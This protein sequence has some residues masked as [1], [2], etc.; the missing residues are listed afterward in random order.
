MLGLTQKE[1]G[2][3]LGGGPSAFVKYEAGSLK[4]ATAL[5]TLLNLL[6]ENPSLI[7]SI[8]DLPVKNLVEYQAS[9][10]NVLPNQICELDKYQF[11]ELVE[12]LL[13]A[14]A[15]SH[16]IPLESIHVA[17][18]QDAADGGEDARISW[19]GVPLRTNFLPSQFVQFQIK[20]GKVSP[21]KSGKEVLNRNEGIKDKVRDALQ[22]GAH[23]VTLN[24]QCLTRKQVEAHEAKIISALETNGLSAKPE[25]VLFWGAESLANWINLYPSIS[26]WFR[27]QIGDTST[28]LFRSWENWSRQFEH[29]ESAW[30]EDE[31][32]K[33]IFEKLINGLTNEKSIRR[34]VGLMGVGKSRL[35]LEVFT[36]AKSQGVDMTP[37]VL[38]TSLSEEEESSVS[39]AVESM[40]IS[41][42]RAVVVVDHCNTNFHERLSKLASKKASRLSLITI[43]HVLDTVRDPTNHDTIVLEGASKP[44][45]EKLIRRKLPGLQHEDCFRLVNLCDGL[46]GMVDT[47]TSAWSSNRPIS[48]ALDQFVI[49]AYLQLDSDTNRHQLRNAAQLIAA[50]GPIRYEC[51]PNES[52]DLRDVAEFSDNL[53]FHELREEANRLIQ[54]G[55]AQL[56]GN[57]LVIQ[58]RPLAMA[59]TEQQWRVWDSKDWKNVLTGSGRASLKLGAAHQLSWINTTSTARDVVREICKPFGTLE[60]IEKLAVPGNA[61]VLRELAQVDEST[62]AQSIRRTLNST[63]PKT[64]NGDLTS[65]LV[66]AIHTIVFARDTF[67][68][69]ADLL[70]ELASANVDN[71]TSNQAA[72]VF[73]SLFPLIAGETEAD[74]NTRLRFLVEKAKSEK[75][76]A[77]R[78]IVVE[79][80]ASGVRTSHFGYL[81]GANIAGSRPSLQ[82]WAPSNRS[83]A[84]NYLIG[85]V[86]T[87]TEFAVQSDDVGETA[88]RVL[89][90]ELRG[91]LTWIPI[92]TIEEIVAAVHRCVGQW[93][94]AIE[95]LGYYLQ[96]EEYPVGSDHPARVSRLIDI[97]RPSKLSTQLKQYVSDMSYQYPEERDIPI[98]E[99][100]EIQRDVI[101]RLAKETAAQFDVFVEVVPDLVKGNQRWATEYGYKIAEYTN[102][103]TEWLQLILNATR[104]TL[105]DERNFGLLA[106]F[107]RGVYEQDCFTVDKL[108]RELV[109]SSE[110]S[111]AF[112]SICKEIGITHEDIVLAISGLQSN[113]LKAQRLSSWGDGGSLKGIE[114]PHVA[115]LVDLLLTHSIDGFL[116]GVDLLLMYAHSRK[117]SLSHLATQVLNAAEYA[118]NWPISRYNENFRHDFAKLVTAILKKGRENSNA[119]K[120]ALSLAR[121]LVRGTDDGGC[122]VTDSVVRILLASFAEIVWPLVSQALLNEDKKNK[123]HIRQVIGKRLSH[124]RS[125]ELP[126]LFELGDET[127]FAWCEAHPDG[128]PAFVA[129]TVPVFIHDSTGVQKTR[130]HPTFL[131]L[132]DE[133]GQCDGVLDA[134]RSNMTSGVWEGSMVPF[135][136]QVVQELKALRGHPKIEVDRW[137]LVMLRY[138][139][140][141]LEA[142]RKNEE[143]L[144][145]SWEI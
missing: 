70:L 27:E 25:K 19:K 61:E 23:Y 21:S 115:S 66:S 2:E 31:R 143:Q 39:S 80:L 28:T 14:E 55:I 69:G 15:R 51:G 8:S 32:L 30:V 136:S 92:E 111:S 53:T 24:T 128:A 43:G 103:H 83:D 122:L 9:P 73:A 94:E 110:L 108:K 99:K 26:A 49:D 138:F 129:R 125:E 141:W 40:A 71:V 86:K 3:M 1:A 75:D 44:V 76:R 90:F 54:L 65:H 137:L 6:K 47:V 18:N 45:I 85:C 11:R 120:L 145:I 142:E 97:L 34:V 82:P 102:S 5:V 144:K 93:P 124:F 22:G 100:F 87:L 109:S 79:G 12:R 101:N 13:I 113:T 112:P 4:P 17:M 88:R 130:F 67:Y 139:T 116:V 36:R 127:L 68:D 131:R 91:L 140:E 123:W 77:T 121:L 133:F 38:Y 63:D 95:Q 134:A 60:G 107:L 62:V 118:L 29:E 89:G 126:P 132:I 10:L 59:L 81:S 104:H 48:Q 57:L 56:H 135:L 7:H 50:F 96:F 58:P 37:L 114:P 106:G 84:T 78:T 64:I 98:E 46:P 119:R 16:G 74:G 117:G 52:N 35:T 105:A 72:Q 42:L 20:S 33:P 41:Q